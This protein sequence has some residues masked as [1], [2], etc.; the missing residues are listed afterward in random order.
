MLKIYGFPMSGRFNKVRM[1]ANA[2]NIEHEYQFV[3]LM[4]GEHKSD[5]HRELHPGGKIPVID[6]DGFILFESNAIIRYL[7]QS[8]GFRLYA[9]EPQ[10]QAL[11]DQW[12]DFVCYHLDSHVVSLVMNK[13]LFPQMGMPIDELAL[14]ERPQF[15]AD[16]LPVVEKRLGDHP[17]LAGEDFSIADICLLTALDPA[18]MIELDLQPYP[19]ISAWR[20]QLRSQKFY[21][22]VHHHFGESMEDTT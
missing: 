17:Y 4:E 1:V 7:C 6:D 15:L 20:E 19:S 12:C 22:D 11:I 21:L 3:N 14:K 10:P 18:E 16:F 2:L 13:V 8:H 9:K 5:R